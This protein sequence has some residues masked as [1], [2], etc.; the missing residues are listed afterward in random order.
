MDEV[1]FLVT[2]RNPLKD[3][4]GLMDF[5]LRLEWV[6]KAVSG[7]PKFKASDFEAAL[8]RPSYTIR[9][10]RALR[11]AYPDCLFHLIVGA[12]NWAIMGQWKD[13]RALLNEFPVR[14]Y[15]RRGVEPVVPPHLPQVCTV[16]APLMEISSSFIRQAVKDGK[17]VRFFV[18]EVLRKEL[19][20]LYTIL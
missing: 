11:C 3:D 19:I 7:Y 2:P 20:Q 6:E 4:S 1:W 14:I 13:A 17:D 5:R 18:P 10:L 15:P 9:T 8:P 16:D 12:D